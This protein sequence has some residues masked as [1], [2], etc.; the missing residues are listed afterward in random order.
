MDTNQDNHYK[1]DILVVDDTVANLRL[2][3]N[4]LVERGYKV[5][6]ASNGAMALSAAQT[7]PPDLILLDIIMPNMDGYEV[8]GQ[9]KADERTGNIP[10]IFISAISE[11]FDKVKAFAI[12]GVDYITKP[13]QVEEVLA[14]VETHL[15]MRSLQKSLEDKNNELG[16]T[17][18]SLKVTQAKLIEAEKNA[19]LGNLVAGVAHEINTPLGISVTAASVLKEDA[20]DFLN[21]YKNG[22]MKRSDLETFVDTAI[23]SSRMI[24]ANLKRAADLV[25]S[26]KQVAV[27][28]STE[29]KRCFNLKEYLEEIMLSLIAELKKNKHTVTIEGD[30][31]LILNSYPGALSQ[32]VTNLVMN[33]LIH[34]YDQGKAGEIKI[35]FKREGNQVIFQYRDDGKGILPEHLSQIF[36]PF[37][38]TNRSQGSTGL[39]L[40]I[41][42]NLV[43]QQ[44]NGT[45]QCESQVGVGTTF[46]IYLPMGDKSENRTTEIDVY[47]DSVT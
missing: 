28:Q 17:L 45:I 20:S 13:F 11:V 1:A 41:V 7:E 25:Q 2:L 21:T 3:V 31:T 27:D 4:L 14:R 6:P 23:D 39:G 9:L 22:K 47:N 26:F 42:Y 46:T 16:K 34:A 43:S 12:G 29:V 40:H 15:A 32:I 37:F 5:R 38:T 24:L 44:L 10:V 35:N 8:C 30:E 36:D 33:S 18:Q 19:A